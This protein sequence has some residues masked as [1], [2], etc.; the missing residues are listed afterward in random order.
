M[1]RRTFLKSTLATAT[2]PLILPSRSRSAAPPNSRIGIGMIGL[3]RQATYANLPPFLN[4][5]DTQV[6]AICDVDTWRLNNAKD[7]IE[8][9]YASKSPS[10]SYKG[11]ALE[12]E[13]QALLARPDVDAVM[14]STPDHWHVPM[15]IAAAKAGK[16][17]ALEKPLTRSIAEGRVM[18]DTMKRYGRIF[19]ND[20]EIR[21]N[22][23]MV[24]AVELVLNGRIGKLKRIIAGVPRGDIAGGAFGPNTVPDELDYPRWLGPAP[25]LPTP[26][27]AST[28]ATIS[29]GPAGC[30]ASTTAT[31]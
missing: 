9:H 4:N 24:R 19:R 31:A 5:A 15:A 28:L 1:N 26:P 16:D 22:L 23:T 30:A 20:T 14:I 6:V 29:A 17:V 12:R 21:S 2:A 11:L 27:T 18:A 13:W 10:G 3:G 8:K 7:I 25:R